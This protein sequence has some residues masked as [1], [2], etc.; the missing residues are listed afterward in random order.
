MKKTESSL[1]KGAGNAASFAA[2]VLTLGACA[3]LC[4]DISAQ[5]PP[6]GGMTLE[7]TISD[8]AQRTTLAFAGLG[9]MTGNL[10]AQSFFP[11]GKVADYTGFQYLRDNDPDSMGHNTSF[12][13]R[14]AN[15]V[16]YLLN[17]AQFAQLK[18]LATAQI[19]Q[20]NLYG[21][22]RFPLMKAFRRLMDGDIPAGSTG[23]N[24]DAVKQA[25]RELYLIDG[26]ISFDRALLYANIFNSMDAAQKAYLDNMKGKGWNSWPDITND[27]IRTRMQGLPQGTAVAVMTYASDLFSWY[28][29]SVDAD[30]YFCPERQGTYYGS[31]YIKDAPAIGHEGYGIDEQLT[32][33]AGA[34][35]CDSSKGYVTQAQAALISS[36]VDTQRNNLY[37]G[38]TSIV[39]VRTQ[40]AT[41]LRGLIVSTASSDSVRTQVLALSGTYGDLDGENNYHYATVFAQVYAALTTVQKDKL[42]TLRKSIMSGTYSDGTPFDFSVCTTPYLYSAAITDLSLLTP[43]IADTDYLFREPATGEGEGEGEP[44]G[45]MTLQSSEVAN[46][47]ALPTEY[48]CDGTAA[49]LPLQWSGAP[50]ETQSYAIIMHHI[51]PDGNKWYWILYDIPANILS[52]AKNATGTGTLGNNSVNGLA[53][54]APPCSQGPGEKTYTLTVYALSAAPQISVAPEQVSRDVLLAAMQGLILDTGELNVVYSRQGEGEP[55][56]EGE[57][58]AE[59][60]GEPGSN[61]AITVTI[62]SAAAVA[63]GAQWAISGSAAW[64]NSGITLDHLAAGNVTVV[65]KNV[66]GW[67]TP[68]D[69]TVPVND[70]QTATVS[71]TYTAVLPNQYTLTVNVTGQGSVTLN[72]P[73]GSYAAGTNVTLTPNPAPGWRFARWE[74]AL[75]TVSNPATFAVNGN[76]SITAVFTEDTA[77][78]FAI[79]PD[80]LGKTL[81]Q[82]ISLFGESGLVVGTVREMH[83][84]AVP[85]GNVVYQDPAG[86]TEAALGSAVD[87]VV[88]SGPEAG[89]GEA[90]QNIEPMRQEAAAAFGQ[91]DADNSGGLSMEETASAISGMTEAVFTALDAN[92]DGQLTP[93]ELG[94]DTA[95]W[96]GCTGFTGCTGGKSASSPG[97]TRT[98]LGD[99][100]MGALGIVLLQVLS[101]RRP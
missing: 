39:G 24:L 43:Y 66:A 70:G 42:A 91:A 8:G 28:A 40:I 18:T 82:A 61:G 69:R 41:L 63:A 6:P 93:D 21:Y 78:Q 72:P 45:S 34:A 27:Q 87:L 30:V 14:V 81:V 51:A 44:G 35:L 53:E 31:F 19:G 62:E 71:A 68:A 2:T 49:T 77:T 65:F 47:G 60:E 89:E 57:P 22:K 56:V 67:T 83:V 15:N 88:S 52:L 26:Q 50:A 33:T 75:T 32:A 20:I 29:G 80:V 10:E 73:G 58:P 59:G 54:Y 13:T 23:L 101:P 4:A 86:G 95:P 48:T 94:M 85:A 5:A 76:T 46:G 36:L 1:K 99:L 3:L 9:M 92:G 16:I 55:P 97:G 12:L 84:A 98:F 79:V 17:D 38:A 11:P 7:Q 96:F 74:G 64:N 100:L 90:P 37:A 25:S